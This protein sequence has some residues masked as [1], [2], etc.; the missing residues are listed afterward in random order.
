MRVALVLPET[1]GVNVTVNAADPPAA[2]VF[3]R[4]IPESTNSLL[5]MLADVTVTEAPVA[6]SAPARDEFRPTVTVPK[7]RLAG[8]TESWPCAVPAPDKAMFRGEFVPSETIARLPL[9]DP[10]TDGAKVAVKVTLWPAVSVVGR[11]RPEI[12]NP[13]PVTLACEIVTSVPP[14]FV[15]VSDKFVELP[16]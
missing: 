6:F 11:L 10:V 2:I 7:S 16:T 4:V 3:G 5:S 8:E 13:V 9:A 15:S 1:F 12:E 14:E